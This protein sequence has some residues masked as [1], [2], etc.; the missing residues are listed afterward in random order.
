MAKKKHKTQQKIDRKQAKQV[1]AL[2]DSKGGPTK[3]CTFP[4]VFILF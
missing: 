3:Y 1:N 4:D 2:K